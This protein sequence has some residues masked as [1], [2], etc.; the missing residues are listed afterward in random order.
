MKH[1]CDR[2]GQQRSRARLGWSPLSRREPKRYMW[3]PLCH[4][5]EASLCKPRTQAAL[6]L[7]HSDHPRDMIETQFN[8]VQ[9]QG[10]VRKFTYAHHPMWGESPSK[11]RRTRTLACI[12]APRDLSR[13]LHTVAHPLVARISISIVHGS[14]CLPG[15][16]KRTAAAMDYRR[17]EG[18]S[19]SL[20]CHTT[21]HPTW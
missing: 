3:R 5:V 10:H 16:W 17:M 8:D 20:H 1:E 6:P 14:F 2:V 12:W 4:S 11:R 9:L 7:V 13:T 15:N 19:R 21:P 18:N